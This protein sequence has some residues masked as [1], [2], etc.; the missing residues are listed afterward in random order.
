LTKLTP[1]DLEVL[2]QPQDAEPQCG[3]VR[4]SDSTLAEPSLQHPDMD[5]AQCQDIFEE[6]DPRFELRDP[7]VV[8]D[9]SCLFE[10]EGPSPP[11]PPGAEEHRLHHQGHS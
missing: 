11:S 3:L 8:C 2:S 10:A 9:S 6:E 1:R 5:I 4:S 7:I